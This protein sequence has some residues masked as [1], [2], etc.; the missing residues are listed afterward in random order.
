LTVLWFETDQL[1]PPRH[2][3]PYFFRSRD[4]S[5][6]FAAQSN[7]PMAPRKFFVGG[8][9]KCVSSRL[10][11]FVVSIPKLEDTIGA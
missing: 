7:Q 11:P 9:W 5:L 10:P 2:R 6:R 3:S 8:N 1:V 4:G